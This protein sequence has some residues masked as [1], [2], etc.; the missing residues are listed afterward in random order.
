MKG[1]C[2]S[3]GKPVQKDWAKLCIE[4]ATRR[5]ERERDAEQ[6]YNAVRR[7]L[8]RRDTRRPC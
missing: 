2:T 7:V 1:N 3:C 6:Q 5:K 8:V 4:C